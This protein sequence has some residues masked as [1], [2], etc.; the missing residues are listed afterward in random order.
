MK[1]KNSGQALLATV[2]IFGLL[3]LAGTISLASIGVSE[4]QQKVLLLQGNKALYA[5]RAGIEEVLYRLSADGNYGA[6]TSATIVSQSL[7]EAT[8]VATISGDSQ[9]RI[10]TASGRSGT[11]LRKIEVT[12]D[13]SPSAGSISLAYAAQVGEGGIEMSNSSQIAGLGGTDGNVYANGI[14]HAVNTAQIKGNAWAVGG[15][16]PTGGNITI[17]KNAYGSVIKN[18]TVNGN[19]YSPTLPTNCTVAGS[20]I[21]TPAP[22]PLALPSVDIA[23]WQNAA[24]A[25]GT[26]ANYSQNSGSATLGPKKIT[27]N[28][29]LSNTAILT[30]TGTLWVAGTVTIQNSAQLRLAES[31]GENGTVILLDHPTDKLN[32]GRLIIQNTGSVNKTSQGGYIIF[33]STN[34]RDTC[35]PATA[36]FNN[37]SAITAIVANDGCVEINNSGGL[38]ALSAKKLILNNGAQI[39]YET[40]LSSELYLPGPGVGGSGGNFGWHISSWNEVP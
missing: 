39:E 17:T 10:A 22:T 11:T 8:Y 33:V 30:V 6:T 38:I 29:T 2:F 5:A 23:Y 20:Q 40:G 21:I 35:S 36:S 1:D 19:T 12:L 24:A 14:I 18:C 34:T 31:F 4:V 7:A 13:A 26:L 15:F 28:L 9:L 16:N 32:N 27:G 37:N 25:G 3:L